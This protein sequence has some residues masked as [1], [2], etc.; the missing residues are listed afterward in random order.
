MKEKEKHWLLEKLFLLLALLFAWRDRKR[1]L[2]GFHL[3]MYSQTLYKAAPLMPEFDPKQKIITAAPFVA[4]ALNFFIISPL[5]TEEM[6]KKQ[7]GLMLCN[8]D[9][10]TSQDTEIYQVLHEETFLAS[11]LVAAT[12]LLFHNISK[13]LSSHKFSTR[14]EFDKKFADTLIKTR[15]IV[16]ETYPAA[17]SQ[18]ELF[19]EYFK[20]EYIIHWDM[21]RYSERKTRANFGT[22]VEYITIP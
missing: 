12:A 11:E 13:F 9:S 14:Y 10:S 8:K 17:S 20:R 18:L 19:L 5:D 22:G 4:Q 16:R 7:L 1:I 6:A 15:M 21:A 2:L 3:D